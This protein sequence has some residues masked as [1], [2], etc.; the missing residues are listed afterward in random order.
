M[1]VLPNWLHETPG[2]TQSMVFIQPLTR[3]EA[4]V[5]VGRRAL[6]ISQGAPPNV[7]TQDTD[8]VK[9]AM[10]ELDANALPPMVV[11]RVLNGI[12]NQVSVK[13]LIVGAGRKRRVDWRASA[14]TWTED[15]AASPDSTHYSIMSTA[16]S[17]IPTSPEYMPTSPN[18]Y[19]PTS[20]DY[21]P[22]SPEYIP[23]S[24]EYMP[25]SPEYMPTSPTY[26]PTSP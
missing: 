15:R 4:A 9:I 7:Q 8:A 2:A 12:S 5:V 1:D 11:L 18:Y 13:A 24:P 10:Q 6:R 26:M 19:I 21:M 16:P 20:P 22:T 14:P 23:S 17:P 3:F 25:T